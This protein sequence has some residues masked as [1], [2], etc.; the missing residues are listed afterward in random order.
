MSLIKYIFFSYF[1]R[2]LYCSN[3]NLIS[4][5]LV[6]FNK[7]I[8]AGTTIIPPPVEKSPLTMPA[9]IPIMTFLTIFFILSIFYKFSFFYALTFVFI[10]EKLIFININSTIVFL[11][12]ETSFQLIASLFY[13][14][15]TFVQ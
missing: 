9:K 13:H 1:S 2:T 15:S 8:N 11:T 6:I 4:K 5:T 12:P 3:I 14:I 10:I 7:Y